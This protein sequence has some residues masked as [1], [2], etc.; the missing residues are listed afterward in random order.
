M[1]QSQI[2]T[3]SRRVFWCWDFMIEADPFAYIDHMAE[4]HLNYLIIWNE[5]FLL[6]NPQ[7]IDYAHKRHIK[8]VPGIGLYS[9]RTVEKAPASLKR[10]ID[11]QGNVILDERGIPARL[12]P[13]NY[14]NQEW[15]EEYI[16]GIVNKLEIDGL[17]FETGSVDFARCMCKRCR[18]IS[19]GEGA[20]QQINPIVDKVLQLNPSLWVSCEF[21]NKAGYYPFFKNLDRR[22]SLLW[23]WWEFPGSVEQGKAALKVRE[24]SGFG[25]Q[26]YKTDMFRIDREN[27]GL[28]KK[29]REEPERSLKHLW[30]WI[31]MCRQLHVETIVF[32]IETPLYTK[33][34]LF[35]PAVLGEITRDPG[36]SWEEFKERLDHIR[37]R[38]VMEPELALFY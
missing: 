27:S 15:M 4:W 36:R 32:L 33:Y 25:F 12:C 17:H 29:W 1:S 20:V 11:A 13:S 3:I 8:I 5:P 34:P 7:V 19:E 37:K 28:M 21:K 35:L 10:A 16:L 31:D 24:N 30:Q 9:Y 23:W 14:E 18:N 2:Y 6:E 38:T 26:I 22:C